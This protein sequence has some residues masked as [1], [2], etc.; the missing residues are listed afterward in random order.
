MIQYGVPMLKNPDLDMIFLYDC[1]ETCKDKDIRLFEH[2]IKW[3]V[4]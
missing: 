1:P 4:S 2:D 3:H